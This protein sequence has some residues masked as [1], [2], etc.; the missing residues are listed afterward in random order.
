MINVLVNFCDS[1]ALSLARRHCEDSSRV[2]VAI[3]ADMHRQ[4]VL[5]Q[6]A[7]GFPCRQGAL[8]HFGTVP[9]QHHASEAGSWSQMPKRLVV[10]ESGFSLMMPGASQA[11][12]D[13]HSYLGAKQ[14]IFRRA[15]RAATPRRVPG[16]SFAGIVDQK[17]GQL[18][19]PQA[20]VRVN[21][22]CELEGSFMQ[23]F[24]QLLVVI[25][26]Y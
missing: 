24:L 7:E 21:D 1:S 6:R 13:L 4:S 10:L 15:C 17:R 8:E 2:M 11:P 14:V 3:I 26:L 9:P 25:I 18:F 23:R 12:F 20:S 19:M 5:R 16:D 22:T